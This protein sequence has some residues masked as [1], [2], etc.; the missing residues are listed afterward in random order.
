M[1]EMTT[2]DP[3]EELQD[4]CVQAFLAPLDQLA[5]ASRVNGRRRARVRFRRLV[6]LVVLL[7]GLGAGIAVASEED[8]TVT[9]ID[10]NGNVTTVQTIPAPAPG[11]DPNCEEADCI[12]PPQQGPVTGGHK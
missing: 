3:N 11:Q 2:N 7:V 1:N 4:V 9:I 5:P 8:Q 6:I 12:V 10:T